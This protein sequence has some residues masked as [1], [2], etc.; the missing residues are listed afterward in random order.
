M[1]HGT[2]QYS[3]RFSVHRHWVDQETKQNIPI[4]AR[5]TMRIW[6]LFQIPTCFWT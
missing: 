6:V 4:S 3:Q 5:L 2:L 1:N